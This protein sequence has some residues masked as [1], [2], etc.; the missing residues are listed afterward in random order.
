MIIVGNNHC[1]EKNPSKSEGQIFI[2]LWNLATQNSSISFRESRVVFSPE[3][4]SHFANCE[5]GARAKSGGQHM[6]SLERM[7]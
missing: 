1:S 2:Y 7:V 5:Q 6:T 3:L 4:F